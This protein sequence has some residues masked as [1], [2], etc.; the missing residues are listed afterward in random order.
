MKTDTTLENIIGTKRAPD[1]SIPSTFCPPFSAKVKFVSFFSVV[2]LF[3]VKSKVV[4][5]LFPSPNIFGWGGVF[6][7]QQVAKLST[8]EIAQRAPSGQS[9][10]PN[11]LPH[12]ID[13]SISSSP[14]SQYDGSF[15][16][17]FVAKKNVI[18][19]R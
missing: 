19:V 9:A 4:F 1:P 16:A 7:A 10:L 17:P 6:F 12:M 14:F 11:P 15:F 8:S 13:G 5:V 3:S 2:L 18:R